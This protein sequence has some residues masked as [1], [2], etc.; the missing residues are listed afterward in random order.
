MRS[1]HL[2]K[3]FILLGAASL[4]SIVSISNLKAQGS[5]EEYLRLIEQHTNNILRN[6]NNLPTYLQ[7]LTQMALAFTNSDTSDTT[8]RLQ[9]NFTQLGNIF[10]DNY[11]KQGPLQQRLNADLLGANA[12][13][14]TMPYANDLVYSTVLGS[15]FFQTDPRN[16]PGGPATA[17]PVYN[18][19]KNTSGIGISHLQPGTWNGP[20]IEQQKYQNY[21]NM[22]M[23]IESFNSYVLN[24][25]FADGNQFNELQQIL[26]T[27][28]SDPKNWFAQVAAE[29]IGY[30]L[31]QILLYQSQM[32]VLMTQLIQTEKQIA[33][34]Q[35]MTNSLLILNNQQNENMLIT[36]AQGVKP[37]A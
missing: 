32:F 20:L 4:V 2:K 33:S 14:A 17:N 10:K 35:V 25:Q 11:A 1:D 37:T 30:V 27:Q 8:A 5:S 3:F 21:Y 6:V 12:S 24:T 26:I 18:Y 15:P 36:K 9:G 19:I 7:N 22:V 29:N 16:P 13:K 31:R 28:A 23:G 34:A